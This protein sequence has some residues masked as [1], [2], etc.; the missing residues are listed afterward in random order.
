MRTWWIACALAPSAILACSAVSPTPQDAPSDEPLGSPSVLTCR[1]LAVETGSIGAGQTARAL[2]TRDQSGTKDDWSRYVEMSPGTSAVCT[3]RLPAGT[4]PASLRALT[5]RLDYRGPAKDEEAWLLEVWDARAGAWASVGDNGFARSWVWSPAQLAVTGDPGRYF[6]GDTLRMR[7]RA[8]ARV[9]AAQ[10]DEWVVLTDTRDA[11]AADGGAPPRADAGD[12]DASSTPTTPDAGAPI[13]TDSGAPPAKD[14]GAPPTPALWRPIP[15]VRWQWQLSGTVDTTVAADVFD[16]DLFESTAAAI[17]SLKAAGKRVICYFSAGS[18]ED[19]R[20]DAAAFPASVIGKPLDGW[21]GEAWLDVR[22]AAVRSVMSA[23]L[24]LAKSKGCDAVEPDN[25]DGY[26]NASGFPLTANDQ[27]DFNRFLAAGAHARGMSVAL[28]ND[29]D[30]AAALVGDFD[31]ALNEECFKY[32][33]C[34]LLSP[35]TKAG[36]AVLQVEYGDAA[37]ATSVCPK[38]KALGFDTLVKKLALDAWRVACP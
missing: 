34:G 13:A 11:G 7:F 20:P 21:P 2:A 4:A 12:A 32:D 38:A 10:L 27:L 30:Q 15:G 16:I 37:L 6:A 23:R 24:D 1:S 22:A 3:F 26:S 28:K 19:W 36:K 5:A 9:D 35:F 8:A 33:E 25:V 14:S 18:R 31:F 29:L 17:A